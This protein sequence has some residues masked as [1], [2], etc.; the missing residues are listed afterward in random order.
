MVYPAWV[1]M[2][3][4]HAKSDKADRLAYIGRMNAEPPLRDTLDRQAYRAVREALMSGAL[5][6]G[7]G[8]TLRG[9]AETL[10]ISRQ[11]AHAALRRLEAEGALVAS[12]SSGTLF[13]PV[14]GA[15]DLEELLDIRIH[16][17]GLAARKA[18][19]RAEPG[20]VERISELCDVLEAEADKGDSRGYALAN[21]AFHA[22]VYAASQSPMLCA[23][24]EPF[25]L[26]I[27]PYVELMMPHREV[28][29]ASIPRHRE[30]VAALA[31]HDAEA[32][33]LAIQQD[34]RESAEGLLRRLRQGPPVRARAVPGMG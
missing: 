20:D 17:E 33:A 25:W 28:L 18:A 31:R 13:V 9:L 26:R 27:G 15:A 4:W 24:I 16:L 6:P 32:A 30:I 29:L 22:A 19:M 2:T 34:L 12:P 8:I 7:Q 14:L 10:G 5:R 1:C 23:A 21:R 11:P 3:I